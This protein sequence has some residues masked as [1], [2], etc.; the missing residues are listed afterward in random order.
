M[1]TYIFGGEY[2]IYAA[3]ANSESEALEKIRASLT[4]NQ[5]EDFKRDTGNWKNWANGIHIVPEGGVL[6]CDHSN[7]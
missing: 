6:V 7:E 5:K 2:T 1:N 3:Q 4:D